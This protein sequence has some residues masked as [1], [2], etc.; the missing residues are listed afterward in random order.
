MKTAKVLE[1]VTRRVAVEEDLQE[2]VL[3]VVNN[4]EDAVGLA[5]AMIGRSD[6]EVF[7][8]ILLDAK[9]R[10]IGSE[11]VSIGTTSQALVHPREVFKAAILANAS[12]I[13]V[14]HNHPSGD[15]T[16]S[17][18]DQNVTKR[19]RDAGVFLGIPVL[20]S[21]VVTDDVTTYRRVV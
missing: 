1:V 18:D 3:R 13:L 10:V 7:L 15:P 8:A 19:L 9:R 2:Y 20:D 17:S 16:P 6:R 14:A 5:T 4:A 12:A 11:R 21:V